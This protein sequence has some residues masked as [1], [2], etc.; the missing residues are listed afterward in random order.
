MSAWSSDTLKAF[1]ASGR[2][3]RKRA[4]P[5]PVSRRT[6]YDVLDAER[7]DVDAFDDE[8]VGASAEDPEPKTGAPARTGGDRDLDVVVR[9]EAYERVRVA[10][11]R[12]VDE[13]ADGALGQR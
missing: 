10:V 4:T 3:R 7:I 9:S 6:R 12:R 11:D 2:L 13:L 1:R 8:H 5:A